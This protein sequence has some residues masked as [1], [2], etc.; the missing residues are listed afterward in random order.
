MTTGYAKQVL[1]LL[2][3]LTPDQRRDVLTDIQ[4]L[5]ED[6]ALRRKGEKRQEIIARTCGALRDVPRGTED[7]LPALF[8]QDVGL[9]HCGKDPLLSS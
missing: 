2:P 5:A 9:F 8:P 1:K 7:Y 3:E 6:A 4:E